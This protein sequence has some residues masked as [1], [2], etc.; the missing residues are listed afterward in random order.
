MAIDAPVDNKSGRN[1]ASVSTAQ[2]QPFRVQRDF[3][4]AGYF[5]KIDVAARITKVLDDLKERGFAL[6]DDVAVPARLDKSDATAVA[7]GN[8]CCLCFD[9]V[10]CVHGV[11]PVLCEQGEEQ[12]F[13]ASAGI[14]A[15][16]FSFI[17]TIPSAPESNR[18]C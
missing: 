2:C 16:L 14:V 15:V 1:D 11:Q 10:R 9:R 18:V 7:A 12:P 8:E 6:V 4:R 5:I 13:P 17:R 3:E